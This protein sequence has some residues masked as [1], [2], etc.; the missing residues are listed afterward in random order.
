MCSDSTKGATLCG[1]VSFGLGCARPE[2]AGVYTKVAHY[3]DWIKFEMN[4]YVSGSR[5]KTT[6]R[7]PNTIRRT[8]P[9]TKPTAPN[10]QFTIPPGSTIVII[11]PGDNATRQDQHYHDH[12]HK[13]PPRRRNSSN[14]YRSNNNLTVLGI[15]IGFFLC[16]I[17]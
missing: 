5:G 9:P 4:K 13:Y 17:E 16:W 3:S 15:L 7:Y 11:K 6:P 2:L 8:S 1:V 14:I 10:K 12:D